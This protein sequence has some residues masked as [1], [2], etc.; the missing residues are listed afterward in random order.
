MTMKST[1]KPKN[2]KSLSQNKINSLKNKTKNHLIP[3]LIQIQIQIRIKKPL[4]KINKILMIK[5]TQSK[6]INPI[7]KTLTKVT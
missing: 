1:L 7:K 3:I 6:I 2:I 5:K 4:K